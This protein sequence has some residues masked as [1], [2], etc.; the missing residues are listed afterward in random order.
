MKYVSVDLWMH[1]RRLPGEKSEVKKNTTGRS[2]Q[3][4]VLPAADVLGPGSPASTSADQQASP[5]SQQDIA[6]IAAAAPEMSADMQKF[7]TFAGSRSTV[8]CSNT[9]NVLTILLVF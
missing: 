5:A 7:I 2:R 3:E 6:A 1:V 8:L 9:L 4:D